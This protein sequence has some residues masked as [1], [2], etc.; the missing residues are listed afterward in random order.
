MQINNNYQSNTNFTGGHFIVPKSS[1]KRFMRVLRNECGV[2]DLIRIRNTMENGAGDKTRIILD[3]LGYIAGQKVDGH[4]RGTVNGKEY[5]NSWPLFAPS[6]W[7]IPRFIEK[8]ARKGDK[9]EIKLRK[10]DARDI[11]EEC[12]IATVYKAQKSAEKAETKLECKRAQ[13]HRK[14]GLVSEK[15]QKG[16]LL[17]EIY[18]LINGIKK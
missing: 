6:T 15:E 4:L 18:K 9:A 17:G 10:K 7:S 16:Y 12:R 14:E 11:I 13:I 2:S 1:Q 3:D 8:L 5:F